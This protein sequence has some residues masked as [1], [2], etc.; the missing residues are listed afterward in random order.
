M[1][2]KIRGRSRNVK[3]RV[4]GPTIWL[5]NSCWF[6][7]STPPTTHI[8][9]HL[10]MNPP[11]HTNRYKMLR[12]YNV[13]MLYFNTHQEIHFGTFQP[14]RHQEKEWPKILFCKLH[15]VNK[16]KDF[17]PSNWGLLTSSVVCKNKCW[18]QKSNMNE[19]KIPSP[20]GMITSCW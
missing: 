10:P 4:Q 6:W 8:S 13:E 9:I 17:D 11:P 5:I 12:N 16:S 15:C 3:S 18:Q 7:K 1:N 14:G 20:L 19:V 2:N